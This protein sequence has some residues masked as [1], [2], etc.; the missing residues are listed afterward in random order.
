[1]PKVITISDEAY[2]ALSSLK[3]RK[4]SFTD[5]VLKLVEKE[6]KKPLSYFAGKWIGDPKEL[7]TIFESIMEERKSVKL[8][9]AEL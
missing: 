1:M 9:E 7:T 3:G 5:T 8:R 2:A 4:E 6:R